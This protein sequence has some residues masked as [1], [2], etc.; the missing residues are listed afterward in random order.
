MESL[1]V[2]GVQHGLQI[3]LPCR[4]DGLQ[5]RQQG[6]L[7]PVAHRL[8]VVADELGQF[9][10]R[11][12]RVFHRQTSLHPVL[13]EVPPQVDMVTEIGFDLPHRRIYLTPVG[14]VLPCPI[15]GGNSLLPFL[16][17]FIFV[18]RHIKIDTAKIG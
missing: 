4:F 3:G 18:H 14:L 13:H 1:H 7:Q 6:V 11:A 5:G 2:A 17:R 16:L 9:T 12:E 15:V 8:P 10:V